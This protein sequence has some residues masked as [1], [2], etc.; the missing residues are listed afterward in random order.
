MDSRSLESVFEWSLRE[1]GK[2]MYCGFCEAV[3]PTLP[4]G[5]HRG[6]GPRG[7][8]V[9]A[10]R[11][12]EEKRASREALA[13]LFS[14]LACRACSFKCVAGIDIAGLVVAVRRLYSSGFFGKPSYDFV[15]ESRG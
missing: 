10:R 14:C 8:V 7:R 5:P 11:V 6:Y 2:C 3:C 13:S 15:V 4:H 1:A 9:I 12:L